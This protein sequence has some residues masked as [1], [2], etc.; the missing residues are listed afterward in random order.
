MSLI[1]LD[2]QRGDDGTTPAEAQP[3]RRGVGHL[4]DRLQTLVAQ[5][6]ERLGA[7]GATETAD[8]AT[9]ALPDTS[10]SGETVETLRR[11]A[12]LQSSEADGTLTVTDADN[13]DASITSDTWESVER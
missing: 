2:E 1:P 7:G 11:H 6:A 12:E 5:V 4:W 10:D 13:P 8:E 9:H 3:R